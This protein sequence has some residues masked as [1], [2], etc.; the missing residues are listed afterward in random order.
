MGPGK[1]QESMDFVLALILSGQCPVGRVLY[2]GLFCLG[3]TTKV[4][5]SLGFV[6]CGK[7]RLRLSILVCLWRI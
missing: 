1:T 5:F 2:S 6:L 7:Y 3:E 4:L